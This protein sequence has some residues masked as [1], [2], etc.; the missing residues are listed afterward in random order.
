MHHN[1]Y[2]LNKLPKT[3]L[4]LCMAA[5]LPSYAQDAVSEKPVPAGKAKTLATVFVSAEG[6]EEDGYTKKQ[7]STSTKLELDVKNT[8]QSVTVVTRKQINDMGAS[9]LGQ[10]LLQTTGII[11]TG[12]NSERTN[13]SM[14]GFNLGDGWNSNLLQYDGVPINASNV[15]ASK[16]DMALVETIEVLRGAAGLMQGSGE[17]SGAI[18]IIR[19]KPTA[20]FQANAAVSYGSWDMYRAEVDVSNSLNESGTV[21]GRVVAAYQDADS[22]MTGVTRDTNLFYGILSADLTTNT[23]LNVSYK[24]QGEHAVGA[25]NLPRDP[26]T[27]ADLELS[28][29]N[30]SCNF[31]D[32]WD[33]S[34]ADG[35]IDLEHQFE[36]GWS[37][38]GSYVRAKIDMDMVFTSLSVVPAAIFDPENPQATMNKYAYQ[39]DQQIEVYDLFSKGKFSLFGREHELVVGTNT[40]SS[41]NPGRWTSWDVVMDDYSLWNRVGTQ[42]RPALIVDLDTF[43]PYD[44]P[45]IAPRYELDGGRSYEDKRQQGVYITSRFNIADPLNVI[46]GVRQSDFAYD[47]RYKSNVTNEF[48]PSRRTKYAKDDVTTPYV[49]VTYEFNKNYTAY[50]SFTDTFVVQNVK[51]INEKLL[52]PI[53]GNVYEVGVKGSFNDDRILAT[54]ATFRTE[55]INRAMV[56]ASSAGKC[57]QNTNGG[58]CNIAAGEVLSE[59]VEA[60]LRGE[61]FPGL[62]VTLGYTH[63]TTEFTKDA[64]NTGRIF[65]ETTPEDIARVF[66]TYQFSNELTIGGGVNYQSEWLVS[67]YATISA[68]QEPYTL[69]N[70]MASYPINQTLTLSFNVDNALDEK[71][72]SYLTTTSNRYGEPRNARVSL[73]AVF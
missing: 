64:S 6:L 67:R 2:R 29:K 12:D 60:E 54:L 39:Y 73:R 7:A 18:N 44:L 4:F 27:G 43:S 48:V 71:Y 1:A 21:R 70:L 53:Q 10:V 41:I 42:P 14:R 25:H 23:L 51:D 36:N 35:F 33:K 45:Y 13:F 28:R 17:P 65:N 22:Y 31:S 49:G 8:P 11:L 72:Y 59:G 15:A 47:S 34:N 24:R 66:A 46:V 16:P 58:Y 68:R 56:D 9:N 69:V 52:D 50:A 57:P 20:D 5:C 63:N 55:Q 40:Q 38:K 3:Y 26:R 32:Y 37:V 62:N 30:C 61:I 19:K